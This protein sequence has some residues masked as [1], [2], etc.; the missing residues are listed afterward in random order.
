MSKVIL[1]GGSPT[2]GK[3]YTARK[4]AEDL[5]LPWISTDTIREQMRW[6]V[7]KEDYPD[8]FMHGDPSV[9]HTDKAVEFL[10]HNTAEEIVE[11]QN[12]ESEDVWKGVRG[13]IEADYVWED[14][15][16]EGVA[17]LPKL[18]ANQEWKVKKDKITAIFLIDEDKERVRNTIFTRGLWD[19]AEKYPDDVKEKEV[20]WVFSFNNY[21]KKE[22]KKY[23]MPVFNVDRASYIEEIKKLLK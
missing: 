23:S 13:I 17:I 16:V 1:I 2:A 18:V 3:S 15:I 10:T 5:K 20:E 8:L 9:S 12:K 4:L 7:R 19:E 22:A 6:I 21:I 11:H 14:F